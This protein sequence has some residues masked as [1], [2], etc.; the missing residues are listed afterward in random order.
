VEFKL[1]FAKRFG[2]DVSLLVFCVDVSEIDLVVQY[3][4]PNKVIMDFDMFGSRVK[5]WICY[6]LECALIIAMNSDRLVLEML[7][8]GRVGLSHRNK[9]L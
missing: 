1:G 9:R 2:E 3:S 7:M 8:N 5:D 4:F 6:N